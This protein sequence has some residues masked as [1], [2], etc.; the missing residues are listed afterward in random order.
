MKI[1]IY[2]PYFPYPVSEGAFQVIY[3]QARSLSQHHDVELICWKTD[4]AAIEK[5]LSSQGDEFESRIQWR[6]LH[7]SAKRE[8]T[9]GRA[10]RVAA[11]LV[12]REPSVAM[13]YYPAADCRRL[14]TLAA[15]EGLGV[16]DLGIY[17]YSYAAEWKRGLPKL[18]RRSVCYLHNIESDLFRLRSASEANPMFRYIHARNAQKLARI[19]GELATLFDE[20]WFIAQADHD[21]FLQ[22]NG[23]SVGNF[24]VVPPS[25][26]PAVFS[27][28]LARRSPD[29][30]TGELVFAFVG[31]LDHAP[32]RDAVV[33]LL[34]EV[35]PL[36]QQR[37]FSGRIWVGGKN[38]DSELLRLAQAYPFV[39]MRG[40]VASLDEWYDAIDLSLA[41][42][43]TGSG[44]RIKVLDSLCH[45]V[46]VICHP[47]ILIRVPKELSHEQALIV[48]STAEEWA[49]LMMDGAQIREISRRFTEFPPSLSGD[50]IYSFLRATRVAR[51]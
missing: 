19:E 35:A 43:L 14:K 30:K 3:D 37:G 9:V 48:K 21:D 36:L 31:K 50:S 13:Y 38:A 42:H 47:E 23:R 33:W 6:S 46:P 44:T 10:S 20:L 1:R 26:D 17:H 7:K 24:R 11:S 12:S 18:E 16:A 2:S 15:S 28:A 40:F 39:E 27:R 29:R 45:A 5:I 49:D 32:N 51:F 8:S 41:P 25:F 4:H 34:R 22:Q